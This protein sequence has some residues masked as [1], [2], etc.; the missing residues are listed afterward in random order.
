MKTLDESCVYG[1]RVLSPAP[2]LPL[3]DRKANMLA[4]WKHTFIS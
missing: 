3:Q 2:E 1:P 4:K